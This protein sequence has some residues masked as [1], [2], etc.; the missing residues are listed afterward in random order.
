[1]VDYSL[2]VSDALSVFLRFPH[3]EFVE[4]Q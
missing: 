2:S 4:V 1:L 3:G